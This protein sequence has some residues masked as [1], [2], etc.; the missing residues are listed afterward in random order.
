ML[1]ALKAKAVAAISRHLQGDDDDGGEWSVGRYSDP[2]PPEERAFCEQFS[3]ETEVERLR[4]Q[5]FEYFGIIERIEKE[6]DGLWRMYRESVSEHLNAQTLLERQLMVTRRQLGRAVSMLNKMRSDQELEPVKQPDNLEPY[7]GEPVGAA[8]DYAA[9]MISLCGKYAE[10]LDRARPP[11]TD[12]KAERDA[13][14][15]E[16]S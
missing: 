11:M 12:G 2:R 15:G 8:K 13:V 14:A 7:E 1:R 6:R 16:Q 9:A 10:A 3:D 4:R 5:C